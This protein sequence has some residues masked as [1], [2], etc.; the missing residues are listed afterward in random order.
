LDSI[1]GADA[2]GVVSLFKAMAVVRAV[3]VVY[4][5]TCNEYDPILIHILSSLLKIRKNKKTPALHQHR[6]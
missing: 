1:S 6:W 2:E 4:L 3:S 5:Q